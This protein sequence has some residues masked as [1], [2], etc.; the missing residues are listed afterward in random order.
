MKEVCPLIKEW[1]VKR[2]SASKYTFYTGSN[3]C[4][5]ILHQIKEVMFPHLKKILLSGNEIESVEG[6]NRIHLPLI[7]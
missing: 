7:E 2:L 6:L 5:T 4:P 3:W 1:K